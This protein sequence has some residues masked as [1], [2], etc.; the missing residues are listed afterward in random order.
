MPTLFLDLNLFFFLKL[1]GHSVCMCF[2][3]VRK[4]DVCYNVPMNVDSFESLD[5]DRILEYV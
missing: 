2:Y 4:N 1:L 3:L 5:K